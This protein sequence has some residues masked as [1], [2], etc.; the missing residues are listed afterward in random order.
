MHDKVTAQAIT[1]QFFELMQKQQEV[2][3]DMR[4]LTEN[5]SV[6]KV[7]HGIDDTE[8]L[9]TLRRLK[10]AESSMVTAIT[11]TELAKR[12]AMTDATTAGD[13]WTCPADARASKIAA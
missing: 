12:S 5:A 9:G 6:F 2:L 4:Q 10:K 13:P 8:K 7:R 1:E 3:R 11:A